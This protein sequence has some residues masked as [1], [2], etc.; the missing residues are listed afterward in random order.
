[1]NIMNKVIFSSTNSQTD[2][3]TNLLKSYNYFILLIYQLD[4]RSCTEL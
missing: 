1:M 4:L 2:A 3:F